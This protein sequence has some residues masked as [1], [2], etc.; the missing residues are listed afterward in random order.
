MTDMKRVFITGNAGSGKTTLCK[1]FANHLETDAV[2]L[3]QFV[4]LPGWKTVTPEAFRENIDPVLQ[5][6]TWVI[7]GVSTHVL[8]HADTVI[9]LD[10]GRATAYRRV[11]K[12][13]WRYLFRSRPEMPENCPEIRI[14]PRLIRIIW[15][16]EKNVRPD[17][18]KHMKNASD[19]VRVFQIQSRSDLAAFLEEAGI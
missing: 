3:D 12:R 9:F 11:L 7:E 19:E 16:F 17:L 8:R 6:D 1:T 15:G 13:N 4:W 5:Q 10:V 14:L 18:I 2:S